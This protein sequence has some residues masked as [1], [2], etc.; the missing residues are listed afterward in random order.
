MSDISVTT[1]RG[2]P[3]AIVNWTMPTAYDDFGNTSPCS[4][5]FSS[6]S[7]S[8][9]KFNIGTTCVT[10]TAEDLL[11]HNAFSTQFVVTVSGM[12]KFLFVYKKD[13]STFPHTTLNTQVA[14]SRFWQVVSLQSN[15]LLIYANENSAFDKEFV[16]KLTCSLRWSTYMHVVINH[17]DPQNVDDNN[18][19]LALEI[20]AYLVVSNATKIIGI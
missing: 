3:T 18:C 19:W 9:S 6:A 2:Q 15:G 10:Y 5:T 16:W 17:S 1:D 4:L 8:G 13:R 20:S 12:V 7:D 14:Y 11:K